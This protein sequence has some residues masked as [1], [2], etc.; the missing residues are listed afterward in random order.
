M[1]AK[2]I[3]G[4]PV[5]ALDDG[6][7]LGKVQD[8]VINPAGKKVEGLLVGEKGLL[9]GKYQVVPYEQ[10]YYIG[11]DFITIKS[12]EDTALDEDHPQMEH[13]KDYSFLGNS[14]I[15]SEGDYI[16]K[17]Q[18]FTFLIETGEIESLLLYDLRDREKINKNVCLSIEGVL[19]L[20]KDYVIVDAD[21]I[22]FLRE[23]EKE[24]ETAK[25][26]IP[27][28]SLE[29]RAIAFT[30]EKEAAHT[31]RDLHGEVIIEKGEK[32]TPEIIDR[33][34]A[35]GRLYQVLF[36]AGVGELLEGIDYTVEKL[37][38]GSTLLLQAWQ[39]L[40]N[41]SR[42][43]FKGTPAA[44]A[45]PGEAEKAEAEETMEQA[46]PEEPEQQTEPEERVKKEQPAEKFSP[47]QEILE[48]VKEIW[49][50]LEKEITREG[51]ELAQESKERMKKYILNKKANYAVRD[52]QGHL[53]VKPG[54]EITEETIE[55]A[56][57]Q[58]KIAVLFL[59]AATQEVEDSLNVIG[60]KISGIFR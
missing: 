4:Y 9:K 7:M 18:D 11:K 31:V 54:E 60:E 40:K 16:A 46:E 26:K 8:L 32:V 36:A 34:R 2:L 19:N 41:K 51:K 15:S 55:I 21:Y 14:V 35:A 10:V 29:M 47:A 23:E 24:E 22:T 45:T 53:L 12:E 20:G 56:E 49:G 17:I 33:A 30:L 37:D 39:S 58:N 38:Q 25:I 52:N 27:A 5:V 1:R 57:A 3:K 42:H 43:I 48:N 50:R 13:F 59:A 6:S 28:Y 44:E